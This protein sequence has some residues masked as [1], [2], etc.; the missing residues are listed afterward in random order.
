MNIITNKDV[1]SEENQ[2]RIL[3]KAERRRGRPPKLPTSSPVPTNSS[4]AAVTPVTTP[5]LPTSTTPPSS[6]SP[7]TTEAQK[8]VFYQASR[9]RVGENPNR[10]PFR[11]PNNPTAS[12]HPSHNR[13]SYQPRP[14][15]P[16]PVGQSPMERPQP[17]PGRF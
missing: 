16:R 12:S 14:T 11:R 9:P 5:S 1:F 17:G 7:T 13:P 8:T 6:S 2:P 3:K 4:P 10:P 15:G